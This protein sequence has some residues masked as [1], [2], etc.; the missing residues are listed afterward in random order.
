ML[1]R[2]M[3]PDQPTHVTLS[4]KCGF[5]AAEAVF[6]RLVKK[7][8]RN[9]KMRVDT[10]DEAGLYNATTRAARRWRQHRSLSKL[11]RN[12]TNVHSSQGCKANL[13]R[14]DG[15]SLILLSAVSVL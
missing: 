3:N 6:G 10:S 5:M 12:R 7:S 1:F 8:S 9:S 11:L 2:R 4:R 15:N 13:L 14:E